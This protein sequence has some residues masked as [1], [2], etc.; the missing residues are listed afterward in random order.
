VAKEHPKDADVVR[1]ANERLELASLP[2]LTPGQGAPA[3][4]AEKKPP[5][6]KQ[7]K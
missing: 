7:R 4:Q 2:P 3:A 6:G 5:Q 1:E